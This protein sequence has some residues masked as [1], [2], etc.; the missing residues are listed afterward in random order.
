MPAPDLDTVLGYLA[1]ISSCDDSPWEPAQVTDALA[2]ETAAQANM[3]RIPDGEW[4]AD[5]TEALL[6][7]VSRTLAMRDSRSA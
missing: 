7:R 6:R 4:P 1:D 5:L 3:C 2:A